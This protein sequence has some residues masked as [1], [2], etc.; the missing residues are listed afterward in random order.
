MA[1]ENWTCMEGREVIMRKVV[2]EQETDVISLNDV[3]IRT[4]IFAKRGDVLA[5]MVVKEEDGW[6]L[7]IGGDAGAT[8]WHPNR[9]ECIGSCIDDYTFFIE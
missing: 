5:G 6:I 4:A 9:R 8:G 7:R 1:E 2:L 3:N